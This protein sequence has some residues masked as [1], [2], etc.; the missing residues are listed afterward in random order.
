MK[1]FGAAVVVAFIAAFVVA[2]CNDYGNTF[3]NNTGAAITS[4]SPSTISAGHADF[5][6]TV[7]GSG[8][9]AKTY[10]TWNGQKL[11][12]T[13]VE[14]SAGDV[15]WL[16]ATVS[17]SLVAK[18]GNN[19]IITQSPFS[20]AGNNGLSNP[21]ILTVT[22]AGNP[23][24]TVSQIS[25][26]NLQA[27]GATCSGFF[28]LTI[29][30]T[31]FSNST[32]TTQQSVVQWSSASLTTL[33]TAS[34][35]PLGQITAISSTQITVQVSNSLLSAA[36]SVTVAVYNPPAA[37]SGG[38]G[39]TSNTEPFNIC[40][41][42]TPCPPAATTSASSTASVTEETPAVSSDG[43]YVAYA[44]VQD[45]H[46]QI[47]LRDTCQGAA[48]GCQSRTTA[49]SVA[50]D[51]TAANDDSHAPSMSS[52]A[53]YVAFSSAASNLASNAPSGRQIYVR[54]TC[55]GASPSCTPA[56]QLISTDSKGSLVGTES[57]LPSVSASGRFIAFVAVT[58]SHAA[59]QSTAQSKTTTS[60]NS[61]YR[62]VFVRD[63]CLGAANCTPVTTRISLQPGDGS[64]GSSKPAGPAISGNS[65][66]VAGT[67]A[68]SSTLF[69][70]SVAVDDR[71][72]VALTGD[73]KKE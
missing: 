42:A 66:Q 35:N 71:V 6:L 67:G 15:L 73:Q 14:D 4:L 19:T 41:S 37:G 26:N 61:G 52:D 58:P 3:Q 44:A 55:I 10:I 27:C 63:T 70:R 32:D 38:G 24:P 65:K 49:L 9:V 16:T 34:G 17:A 47:F 72:F 40:S 31:N 20:G 62:Q 39:G 8:F 1:R 13:P 33:T 48:S 21:L 25:P 46:S 28:T 43:R 68:D 23:V 12:T 7:N 54:D 59:S 36:G 57:I 22:P 18:P 45:G 29:T 2:G 60:A 51:G 5:T 11:T 50:S 69:T 53:R 30:G 56:T 64:G